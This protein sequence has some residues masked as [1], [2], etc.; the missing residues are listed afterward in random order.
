MVI[1]ANLCEITK[2]ASSPS[3]LDR[4]LIVIALFGR[5]ELR[6]ILLH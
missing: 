4:F 2:N 1:Y 3:F 6:T 5:A